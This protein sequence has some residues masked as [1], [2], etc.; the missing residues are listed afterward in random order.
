[1]ENPEVWWL[2]S[3]FNNLAKYKL[4]SSSD[5]VPWRKNNRY[6]REIVKNLG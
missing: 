2:C 6:L 1:M 4:A 3:P 5:G